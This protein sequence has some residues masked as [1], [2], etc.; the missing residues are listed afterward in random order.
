MIIEALKTQNAKLK[1]PAGVI[2]LKG[3]KKDNSHSSLK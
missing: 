1:V 2:V 3:K